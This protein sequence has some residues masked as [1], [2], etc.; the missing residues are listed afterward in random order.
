MATGKGSTAQTTASPLSR[1]EARTVAWDLFATDAPAVVEL[2]LL[3]HNPDASP[4]RRYQAGMALEW[5]DPS[6]DVPRA[7]HDDDPEA[8]KLLRTALL[9]GHVRVR[10]A[11]GDQLAGMLKP[12]TVWGA[13]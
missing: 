1:D 5:F 13:K 8:V 3:A 2:L 11:A 4:L 6:I 7:R 10:I 9:S 12:S